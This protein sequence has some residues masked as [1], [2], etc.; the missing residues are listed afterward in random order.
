VTFPLHA[1][2]KAEAETPEVAVELPVGGEADEVPPVS[3]NVT[4]GDTHVTPA[5]LVG[6][7]II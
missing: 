3:V 1:E 5:G 2:A 4:L 7:K 6:V